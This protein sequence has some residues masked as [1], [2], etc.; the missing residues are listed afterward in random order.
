MLN[1]NDY[2]EIFYTG[3]VE[4]PKLLKDY[5]KGCQK[6]AEAKNVSFT[7]FCSKLTDTLTSI[8]TDF[9][10]SYFTRKKNF[11]RWVITENNL[12]PEKRYGYPIDKAPTIDSFS[13]PL[14]LVTNQ[15][16]S[17][18]LYYW[19]IIDFAEA[20]KKVLDEQREAEQEKAENKK[21]EEIK[22]FDIL[23][24]VDVA[25]LERFKQIEDKATNGTKEFSSKIRCA[26]FCELLMKEKIIKK[27]EKDWAKYLNIFS[28]NRYKLDIGIQLKPAKTEERQEHW[29]K[30]KKGQESLRNAFK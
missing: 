30:N 9:E 17:D 8:K 4:Y 19:Q 23:D 29:T 2:L 1:S 25:L 21:D 3:I 20:L 18:R 22:P 14:L 24:Y 11:D 28:Q 10:N 7:M 16:Y 27:P 26:A 15:K 12:P 6:E 5:I 13:I